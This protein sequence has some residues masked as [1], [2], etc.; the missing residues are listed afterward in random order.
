MKESSL[1]ELDIYF[2]NDKR[3]IHNK[4]INFISLKTSDRGVDLFRQIKN[5][6]ESIGVLSSDIV[7]LSSIDP[8]ELLAGDRFIGNG[9]YHIYDGS[10]YFM[11]RGFNF[12]LKYSDKIP[13]N[14]VCMY[15]PSID[16]INKITLYDC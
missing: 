15:A 7:I 3:Y 4:N 6:I 14:V 10:L 1:E 11:Y 12:Y 8:C 2:I 13:K 5:E 16:D 9:G